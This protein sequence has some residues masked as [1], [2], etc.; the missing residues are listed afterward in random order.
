MA[1]PRRQ[2]STV[3]LFAVA[4]LTL[5]VAWAAGVRPDAGWHSPDLS[6]RRQ[7]EAMFRGT[8]ALQPLPHG[9]R[10]DWAWGNGSQQVWGLGVPLLRMPGEVL[11]RLAGQRSFPDRIPLIA[12]FAIVMVVALRAAP[13]LPSLAPDLQQRVTIA[14]L[15]G[16]LPAF[17]T[18]IRTRMLVY[19]EA[20]AYAYLWAALQL[21][22]LIG[23]A[24]KRSDRWAY[25]AAAAAGLGAFIRPTLFLY[26]VVTVG[27]LVFVLWR[28]RA[29]AVAGVAIF[30][31]AT[32]LVLWTNQARFGDPLEF[33]QRVNVSRWVLD[34]YAKN[35]D[36]PFAREPVVSAGRELLAALTDRPP[37][38]GNEFYFNG[39]S[40]HPWL[41]PAV[42]FRE[43][44]FTTGLTPFL[45]IAGVAWLLIV[46]ATAR[47]RSVP[48]T[49]ERVV[50]L[51]SLVA[52]AL[53][54]AF[55][56]RMPTT[57]SRYVVDLAAAIAAGIAG[58]VLWLFSREDWRGQAGT[59]VTI[60]IA[61]LIAYGLA[62]AS[63]AP[64]HA[65]RPLSS[66]HQVAS[67]MT[68]PALEGAAIPSSYRCGDRLDDIGV[69]FNG[70]GW[71]WSGDCGL[72]AGTTMFATVPPG[73][74]C[75]DI[76]LARPDGAPIPVAELDA[77]EV[78]FGVTFLE[79]VSG[80]G[81]LFCTPRGFA[82]RPSGIEIVSLK[83]LAVEAVTLVSRPSYRMRSITISPRQ[84]TKR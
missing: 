48:P 33:G 71:A 20:V 40:V 69:P 10:A 61:A 25:A 73:D 77:V 28:K 5:F 63:I 1:G 58:L 2:S 7:T 3:A 78:K 60:A 67:S 56:L 59:P 53:L 29:A 84:I 47:D 18:L 66:A 72:A 62:T 46:F 13:A 82:H 12:L 19:E 17:I 79:R 21:A 37:F 43:F 50:I 70:V 83:W 24:A 52:F 44:Y 34:Q 45:M 76:D 49:P 55:Y 27:M 41:S 11:A 31:V 65:A 36:H 51:W 16:L 23:V 57:T 9:Q 75:V 80:P 38:T 42:R 6:Y 64:T 4:A 35:F 68:V 81:L 26:G 39:P 74:S 14:M 54:A 32:L 30:G 8:F 22:L 15:L